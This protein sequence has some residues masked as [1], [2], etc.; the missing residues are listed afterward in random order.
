[1]YNIPEIFM[2]NF[3]KVELDHISHIVKLG[4]QR[5]HRALKIIKILWDKC[6]YFDNDYAG[7]VLGKKEDGPIKRALKD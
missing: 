3:L 1:M 6:V 5:A 2:E 4:V 7:E